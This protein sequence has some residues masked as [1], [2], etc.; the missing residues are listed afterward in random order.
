[1]YIVAH[2]CLP[3]VYL[4]ALPLSTLCVALPL[5]LRIPFT[6]N[7]LV[8]IVEAN[9]GFK[10]RVTH[11]CVGLRLYRSPV[12]RYVFLEVLCYAF[13]RASGAPES[14]FIKL[15]ATLVLHPTQL[16]HIRH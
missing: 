5:H 14:L 15:S 12:Q 7:I 4:Y 10:F 13:A 16:A 9:G 1:M 3:V 2:L 6:V 11:S 8:L